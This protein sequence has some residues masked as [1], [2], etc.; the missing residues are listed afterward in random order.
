M[1][2]LAAV[3]GDLYSSDME[4]LSHLIDEF[5]DMFSQDDYDLGFT[6]IMTHSMD[7]GDNKPIRQ[8]L[9]KHPLLHLQAMRKQTMEMLRQDIIEH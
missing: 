2:L 4:T 6:D 9:R 7:T 8:S 1:D 3:D 5:E